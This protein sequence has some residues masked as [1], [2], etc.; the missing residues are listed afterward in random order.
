MP[1]PTRRHPSRSP[2]RCPNPI[3]PCPTTRRYQ[4]RSKEPA[5]V[6]VHEILHVRDGGRTVIPLLVFLK[7]LGV[8]VRKHEEAVVELPNYLEMEAA[9]N[10]AD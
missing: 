2:A 4:K 3:A 7:S 9:K 8:P 10:M 6:T 1:L 5:N